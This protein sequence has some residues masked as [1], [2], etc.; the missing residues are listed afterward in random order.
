MAEAGIWSLARELP[1]AMGA[2][3]KEKRKKKKE[4]VIKKKEKEKLMAGGRRCAFKA[5]EIL[6]PHNK[7]EMIITWCDRGIS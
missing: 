3:E 4:L 6:N 2:A 5:I 1:Y 7:K